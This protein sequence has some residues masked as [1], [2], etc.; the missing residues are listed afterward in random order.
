MNGARP[1]THRPDRRQ[2]VYAER[3]SSASSGFRRTSRG[4][5]NEWS[6]SERRDAV[7]AG[8]RSGGGDPAV[9]GRPSDDM[10][11][12]EEV[13]SEVWDSRGAARGH[14]G[15]NNGP[16]YT[17]RGPSA[18]AGHGEPIGGWPRQEREGARPVGRVNRDS[19]L[20]TNKETRKENR[21][22]NLKHMRAT[23][24]EGKMDVCAYCRLH[25]DGGLMVCANQELARV[26]SFCFPCL[27]KKQSIE[28]NSLTAGSIK[29]KGVVGMPCDSAF[30]DYHH[31]SMAAYLCH[32]VDGGLSFTSSH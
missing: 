4:D 27:A 29:V 20:E 7:T 19:G 8:S 25:P 32:L 17:R 13:R 24:E 30:L 14:G 12:E 1:A 16:S 31:S 28:K 5:G 21:R 2:M 18:S 23:Q 11:V 26:H 15:S 3:G 9:A 10:D 22:W 6:S